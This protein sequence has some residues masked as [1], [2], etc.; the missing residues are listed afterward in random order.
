M[1]SSE[2]IIIAPDSFKGTISSADA[3]EIIAE[4]FKSAACDIGASP[5]RLSRLIMADGGEGTTAALGAKLI[6]KDVCGPDALISLK[7]E[8]G[9]RVKGFSEFWTRKTVLPALSNL[10]PPRRL[11][12]AS[13]ETRNSRR[14]T[15]S[16]SLSKPPSTSG[17]SG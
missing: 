11:P 17:Q 14:H 6:Y 1:K 7:G 15:A 3:G 16:G 13:G 8:T 12:K 2:L 9:Q 5:P 10:P 4:A